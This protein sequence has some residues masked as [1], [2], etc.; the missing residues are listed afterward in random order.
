METAKIEGDI[1]YADLEPNIG[2]EPGKRRPVLIVQGQ[3]RWGCSDYATVVLP[4]TTK[5]K[6]HAQFRYRVN[7]RKDLREDSD[8]LVDWP[9]A[10]DNRRFRGDPIASLSHAEMQCVR[11]KLSELFGIR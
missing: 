2:S 9:R 3:K 7:K 10:I 11:E 6:D 4:L 1:W 5:L 8:V